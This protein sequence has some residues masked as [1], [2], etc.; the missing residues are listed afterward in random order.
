[1]TKLV[2][3][4]CDAVVYDAPILK[5]EVHQNYSGQARVLPTVFEKQDY[6]FAL[7]SG[8]PLVEPINQILLRIT[9]EP[10][11]HDVQAT[12]LGKKAQ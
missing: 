8:S 2:D 4:K 11:W 12:Y 10:Q 3:K 9:S 5:Y 6:A 1:M 7:P